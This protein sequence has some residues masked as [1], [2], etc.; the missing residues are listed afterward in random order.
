M[1]TA[2]RAGSIFP[3]FR[4]SWLG[5]GSV[6]AAAVALASVPTAEAQAQSIPVAPRAST[7]VA[8]QGTPTV[9]SGGVSISQGSVTDQITVSTSTAIINWNTLD[10]ATFDTTSDYVN[11]LPTGTNLQFAGPGADYA[12]L[13]RIFSAPDSAGDFRGIAFGGNVTSQL[14]PGGAIGG[15]IWFYSPGGILVGPTATFNVGSLLLTTSA[16]DP[17]GLGTGVIDLTGV[18]DPSSTITIDPGATIDAL[19][20]GSYVGI[21]APRVVQN[22]DVTVNGSVAYV[23]AEEATLTINNGLF[24]ISVGLGTED[25]NGVV[26]GDTGTTTGPSST[27]AA[28][29]QGIY[30][31]AVPK[32]DAITM[33]VGGVIGYQAASVA[34]IVNG[35]IVLTTGDTVTVGGSATAPTIVVDKTVSTD[36]TGNIQADGAAFGS[37]VTMFADDTIDLIAG[38]VLFDSTFASNSVGTMDLDIAAGQTINIAATAAASVGATGDVTLRAGTGSET[39]GNIN[40]TVDQ[41]GFTDSVISGLLVGGDLTIDAS[42]SGLDDFGSIRDNGNTGI[43]TDATGGNVTINVASGGDIVVAGNFEIDASAQ[44]GKGEL[45]SGDSVGGNVS[46]TMSSGTINV[47]GRLFIDTFAEDAA[48]AKSTIPGTGAVGSDSIAGDVAIDI[49]GG[50]LTTGTNIFVRAYASATDGADFETEQ[51]N[52]ATAGDVSINISGG[53]H[54]TDTFFI[55]VNASGGASFDALGFDTVG[56]ANRGSTSLLR[57]PTPIPRSI[58]RVI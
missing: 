29:A 47:G 16:P 18:T 15:T 44:G 40:I 25:A 11:F 36:A 42:G 43:G 35:N 46:L 58:S 56:A 37:N 32:N 24:D 38:S 9:E 30:M 28:D 50:T 57:C 3:S 33:L 14:A 21:V 13:N 10:T 23:G 4:R 12:V 52:D 19:N 1:Q 55:N 27:G 7:T 8:A 34:S 26:H 5:S 17:A 41:I 51:S 20:A 49:S 6:T 22:G 45:V 31:V 39:G 53:S 54:S 2:Q 48:I